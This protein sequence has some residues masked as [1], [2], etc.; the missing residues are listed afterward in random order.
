MT[1]ETYS[2][3]SSAGW[4]AAAIPAAADFLRAHLAAN[5][6]GHQ[7]WR[8]ADLFASLDVE[9]EQA[10]TVTNALYKIR[11]SGLVDDCYRRDATKRHMG[12]ALILW[13]TPIAQ[14]SEEDF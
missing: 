5:L 1:P 14:V 4:K 9:P 2:M 8:T 10:R 6:S 11:K 12:H 3:F 7:T 13:H